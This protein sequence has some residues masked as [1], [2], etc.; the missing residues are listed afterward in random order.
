[1][2]YSHSENDKILDAWQEQSLKKG[3][4][5]I[6]LD[7]VA[8]KGCI[9]SFTGNDGKI[10]HERLS[11][12]EED[13]WNKSS[14][15]ILFIA[16]ELN[17]PDNPYDSRVV[18]K[19]DPANGIKV[20]HPF[21]KS[22]LFI[23][24]GLMES[25]ADKAAEFNGQEPME[26]LM[27][28]WDKAAVAKINVKKQP[29][30]SFSDMSEINSSMQEYRDLL[31]KQLQLLE[32]NIIVCCDNKAGIL[33]TI[34]ELTYPNAVQLTD[35]VWYDKQSNTLLIESYHLSARLSYEKRYNRVI[36]NYV[37]AL[38]KLNA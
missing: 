37:D 6:E 35:E 32:A 20:S 12:N 27:S 25:T 26:N 3:C 9:H 33:S 28:T 11:G 10:Y 13:I 5:D 8:Y 29:G 38:S 4:G 23:T 19:Y 1:M 31:C 14:K 24:K 34:K 16:K 30:G 7:G 21:L 15:R 17:D 18:M 36:R 2:K 22:M